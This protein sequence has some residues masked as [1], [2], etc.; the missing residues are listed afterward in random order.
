MFQFKVQIVPP[1]IIGFD[2]PQW[3]TISAGQH[4]EY[5]NAKW[6]AK[7]QVEWVK[8]NPAQ[9]GNPVGVR[10]IVAGEKMFNQSLWT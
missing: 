5:S 6:D 3:K 4:P 1:F 7:Q 10:A 2:E 8:E 9:Y